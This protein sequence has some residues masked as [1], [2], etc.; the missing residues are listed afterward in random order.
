MTVTTSRVGVGPAV[1]EIHLVRTAR[2]AGLF[3]LSF[4]IAGILG[5]LV[6]R[7]QLFVAGDGQ[8]TLTNLITNELMARIGVALELSI[9]LT[10]ALTAIWLYRLFSSVDRLAAGL[11]TAFG[12][13]NAVAIL[14]SAAL[15]ATAVDVA[16]GASSTI[17]GGQAW[18]VQLLYVVSGNLWGVAA[19]FFGLWLLPMGRLVLRSRWLPPVLGWTLIT[20]GVGYMLSAFVTYL[21]PSADLVS[22]LLT[23]PSIVGEVWIT[24]Y[25]IIIGIRRHIPAKRVRSE[26]G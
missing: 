12:L 15:L 21:F 4:F 14:T 5:S 16:T 10:Q 19:L 26:K 8:A 1:T 2:A 22:Q 6:V 23:V 18:T 17:A 3:Y 25:L 7:G 9:V 11:L 20:G 13:A 24:G